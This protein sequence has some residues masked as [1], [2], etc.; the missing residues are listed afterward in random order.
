MD[1]SLIK[2]PMKWI[3]VRKA[4][5]YVGKDTLTPILLLKLG[6]KY[7]VEMIIK[8]YYRSMNDQIRRFYLHRILLLGTYQMNF[9]TP[10]EYYLHK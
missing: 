9:V 7:L 5:E 4:G 2:K 6:D 10:L 8:E 1:N 3:P